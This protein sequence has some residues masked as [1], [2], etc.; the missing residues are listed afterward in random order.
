MLAVRENL[1]KFYGSAA[2]ETVIDRV[3]RYGTAEI[4]ERYLTAIQA[5]SMCPVFF[6]A[7]GS[8]SRTRS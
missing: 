2:D 6:A 3:L 5:G 8:M 1:L 4:S 7:C